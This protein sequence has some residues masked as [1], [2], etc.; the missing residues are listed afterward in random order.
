MMDTR[1]QIVHK[2]FEALRRQGFQ[3]LRTDKVI[4]ELGITKGAYYHYFPDKLSVGYAVTD[5]II[6][7][8]Y[9]K[10]WQNLLADDQ[11]VLDNICRVLDHHKHYVRPDNVHLGCPLN[12][13]IQEM[14]PLDEGFN[15]RLRRIV[16]KQ[17]ALIE[18]ALN[19]GQEAGQ[20]Q[21]SVVPR[22]LA[23]FILSALE[24]CYGIAK[25]L[26]QKA[27][28]DEGMEQLKAYLQLLRR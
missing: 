5:E 14:S 12:N 13:L 10:N 1:T 8:M 23:L 25:A 2:T 11:P 9:I 19:Y 22:S 27:V 16:E 20:I 4:A 17:R 18:A 7:P 24:G 21:P 6:A 3:G 26:Q 15:L 28:F